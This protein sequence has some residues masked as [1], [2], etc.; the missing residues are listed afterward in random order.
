MIVSLRG[1][2]ESSESGARVQRS[3]RGELELADAV[4][5]AMRELGERFVVLPMRAGVLDL[6]SRADVAHM[7]SRL[8][9]ITPRP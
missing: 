2:T 7:A 5:L 3:V 1:R 9:T 4:M 6:S 8:A